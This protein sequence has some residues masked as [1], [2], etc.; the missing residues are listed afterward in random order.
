VTAL[1]VFAGE[2][3]LWLIVCMAAVGALILIIAYGWHLAEGAWIRVTAIRDCREVDAG[4]PAHQPGRIHANRRHRRRLHRDLVLL[5]V[6]N[7]DDHESA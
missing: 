6:I 7:T 1:A 3:F 2:S 5:L 4:L